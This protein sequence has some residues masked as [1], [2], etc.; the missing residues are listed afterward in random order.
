MSIRLKTS[1]FDNALLRVMHRFLNDHAISIGF[2]SS[3]AS[4]SASWAGYVIQQASAVLGLVAM[5]L[6]CINAG[7]TFLILRRK[8]KNQRDRGD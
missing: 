7:V 6:A 1:P 5:L 8:W 2:A 4:I 3:I